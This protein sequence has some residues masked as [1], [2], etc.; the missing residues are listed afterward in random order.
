[1][2]YLSID[3]ETSGLDS[4]KHTTLSIAAIVED[5]KNKLPFDQCPKFNVIIPRR[6][7][8]GTPTALIMNGDI[9]KL[10]RDYID[11][12]DEVKRLLNFNSGYLF[13]EESNVVKAFYEFLLENG[14]GSDEHSSKDNLKPIT[15]NVAGKNFATFDQKFLNCLPWWKKLIRVRSRILDPAMLFWNPYEDETLPSLKECKERAQIDPV[16]KHVAL[17]DA[18]DVIQ[19]MRN[20]Y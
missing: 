17:D 12:D 6:D 5:T 19:L 7:I 15:I 10:M 13:I 16:V 2:K 4:E 8:Y 3:I 1:M 18:W 11:G 9:I 14:F 20:F